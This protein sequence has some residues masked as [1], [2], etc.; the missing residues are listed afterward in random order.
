VPRVTEPA[1]PIVT[2]FAPVVILLLPRAS[3]FATVM[4]F[5]SVMPPVL[6]IVR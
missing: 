4:S 3:V 2:L 5:A 6:L 1:E